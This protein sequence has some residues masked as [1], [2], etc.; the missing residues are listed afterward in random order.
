MTDLLREARRRV[1]VFDGAMGTSIQAH[2][3]TEQTYGGKLG[4]NDYLN[5]VQPSMIQGI[6]EDFLRAGAEVLE[7][8]TFGGNL[9]KLREYGLGDR[10]EE[11]N[12][13]AVELAR[14]AIAAVGAPGPHWIAGSIGPTG[15]LPSL[16]QSDYATLRDCVAAQG[17]ALAKGGVDLFLVET[18]QDLL[19]VKAAIAGLAVVNAQLPARLPVMISVSVQQGRMLLGTEMSALLSLI[20]RLPVDAVGLNCST[21]PIEMEDALRYLSSHTDLPVSCIPNAGIPE[22]VDG[23]SFYGLTAQEMERT[24]RRYV[25]ELGINFVGGCC[26]T[27]PQHIRLLRDGVDGLQPRR[28]VTRPAAGISSPFRRVSVR[29]DPP[30]LLIG[31]RLNALGYGR[32]R[33]AFA[34]R[35]AAAIR[36]IAKKQVD[37]GAQLLDL[38]AA[39]NDLEELACV[40]FAVDA[41]WRSDGGSVDASL[42]IDS[43]EP[44]VIAAALERFPGRAVVNSFNLEDEQK[45]RRILEVVRDHGALVVG[46]TIDSAGMALSAARKCEVTDRLVGLAK[47]YGVPVHDLIIDPLTFPLVT[48]DPAYA[49]AGVQTLDAIRAIKATYPQ[50]NI[51]LGISNC[52]FG[53]SND[54]D[55]GKRVLNSLLLFHAVEAGLDAAIVD[56]K[57]I[58]P[59]TDI[60][61]EE[62]QVTEDLLF[63]RHPKA[64]E[65][66]L[67]HFADSTAEEGR[68]S[69]KLAAEDQLTAT[70]AV[71][72]AIVHRKE[73]VGTAR[74]TLI[75]LL[76]DARQVVPPLDL[77]NDVL[78][79]AMRTVGDQFGAGNIALPF[80]LE[81]AKLMKVAVAHLEPLLERNASYTKGTVVLATVYGDVHDI[82]KNLV[83]TIL[84]NNGYE[85]VDLGKQVPATV[86]L[87]KAK[88]LDADAIGLSALLVSTSQQMPLIAK[89]LQEQGLRYPLICGGAAINRR[90]VGRIGE[91]YAGGA[92]YA[93]DAFEGLAILDELV[94]L[95][96]GGDDDD[97][98]ATLHAEVGIGGS[99]SAPS[100]R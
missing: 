40:Q 55:R 81:S 69:E 79:S 2:R 90:F 25:E 35:D 43:T 89:L 47:E 98:V 13:A 68:V 34:A 38:T 3:P 64:L 46:L 75:Q 4:C 29:Q 86:I 70:E 31:E 56:A 96:R 92:H 8:N 82:G 84:V 78:I 77:I 71:H 76:D 20:E 62:R 14:A 42:Q 1:V 36:A 49:D 66:F 7:T 94:A 21:G 10:L 6:H 45:G 91:G 50:I 15:L 83:R 80:V 23:R 57:H 60:G 17:R 95:S 67:G 5:L 19:E 61:R 100:S 48:G 26:G 52:S 33:E 73:E 22:N 54:L 9:P 97:H 30:P 63:A 59:I 18:S 32:T 74:R 87:E 27:T 16:G 88:E 11:V 37:S 85:V 39:H 24:L 51:S 41:L 28:T 93:K 65:A 72:Y 58:L 99:H 44:E 12:V 53:L